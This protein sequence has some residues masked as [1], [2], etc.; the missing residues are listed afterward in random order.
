[1]TS[2]PWNQWVVILI[3]GCRSL[4]GRLGGKLIVYTCCRVSGPFLKGPKLS[5]WLKCLGCL[6]WPRSGNCQRLW[7]ST[8]ST[9]TQTIYWSIRPRVSFLLCRIRNT[10]VEWPHISF[11]KSPQLINYH[12]RSLWT[13]ILTHSIHSFCLKGKSFQPVAG[14]QVL[15]PGSAP[16]GS[17]TC[18]VISGLGRVAM[19][20]F[21]DA[22]VPSLMCS[23]LP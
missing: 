6:N 3:N 4:W 22:V 14:G 10:L 18:G 23:S 21:K 15:P 5:H 19:E 17:W 16:L 2:I 1:M 8:E 9:A 7:P 20:V 13:S 11:P 12:Q